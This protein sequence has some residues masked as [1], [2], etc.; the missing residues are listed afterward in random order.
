MKRAADYTGDLFTVDEGSL[1]FA[2]GVKDDS[3][4]C[5]LTVD[6]GQA[7]NVIELMPE[8][9]LLALQKE[10]ELLAEKRVTAVSYTHLAFLLRAR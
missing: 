10:K 5:K 2:A 8:E 6:G 1:Q 9:E 3:T 7:E 4:V